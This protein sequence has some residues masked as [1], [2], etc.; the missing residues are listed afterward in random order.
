MLL[1]SGRLRMALRA[2]A[3]LPIMVLVMLVM[4]AGPVAAQRVIVEPWRPPVVVLPPVS[5][6]P[7]TTAPGLGGG[8]LQDLP[9]APVLTP[10]TSAPVAA[11]PARIVR[12]RC[13][14]APQ[15]QAC[16]EPGSADGG[17]DDECNCTRDYC[18]TASTGVRVCEKSR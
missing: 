5:L 1:Y 8:V 18:Y 14:L 7:P 6:P 11:A 16:R 17:G 4:P 2:A 3:L 13:E 12:F 10:Q 15:E 9:K